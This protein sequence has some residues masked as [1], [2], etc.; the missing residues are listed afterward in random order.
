MCPPMLNLSQLGQRVME[1]YLQK[2]SAG[3]WEQQAVVLQD[4]KLSLRVID[5]LEDTSLTANLQVT[6]TGLFRASLPRRPRTYKWP[7]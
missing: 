3:Q 5:E 6:G 7:C 2:N 4:S 1:I